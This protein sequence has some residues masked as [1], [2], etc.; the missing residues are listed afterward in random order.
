MEPALSELKR[1]IGEVVDLRRA[2]NVLYWDQLVLMPDAGNASRATQLAT[3][4]S[5]LHERFVDDRIGQL[6][7]ELRPPDPVYG[8]S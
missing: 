7:E 8:A 5:L 2:A 4:E 3:L 1:R 6:L